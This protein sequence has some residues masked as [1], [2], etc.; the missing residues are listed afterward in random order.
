LRF[1]WVAVGLFLVT[2]AGLKAHGLAA[3]PYSSDSIF[4]T[5]RLQIATIEVEVLL[6]L[7]LLSGWSARAAAVA[8]SGFFGILG[9]ASLYLALAGQ[10]SCGCFGR[11]TVSPWLTFIF[12][13]AA[14]GALAPCWYHRTHPLDRSPFAWLSGVLKTGAGAAAFLVLIGGSFLLL[15]FDNPADAVARLRGESL[16]VDQGVSQLGDGVA[17]EKRTFTMRLRN[18][19]DRPIR[20][21]GGTTTCAC[22]ATKDL[23]IIVP[24]HDAQP[25]EVQMTFRGGTG[26]FQH[27]FVLYT[28][29]EQQ[30]V[31]VARFSGRVVEPPLP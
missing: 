24:P 9:A 28:D 16:T 23:P 14:I 22:I 4:F 18:H 15:A 26:R 3:D 21:V 29:D 5:P 13:I 1:L 31:V 8:A 7:W 20:V 12:D 30:Q 6:G 27:R 10:R 25:M 11:L 2:A 19:T 17:G